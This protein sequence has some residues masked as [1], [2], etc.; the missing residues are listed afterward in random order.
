ML[1]Q[2]RTA[3]ITGGNTGIGAGIAKSFAE[4]GAHVLI[5]YFKGE[6]E[7]RAVCAAEKRAGQIFD[8]LQLDAT[9]R[10]AVPDVVARAAEM[11]GGK[12]D[13]LVNNAGH[14]LKRVPLAEM[15]EDFFE[16]VMD[17]NLKSTFRVTKA[18]LPFIPSGGNIV[19]MAS[20]AAFN[21]GSAGAGAYAASKGAVVSLTRG[22]A[23]E[24]AA[25]GIRVNVVAPGFIANTA[26]HNTFSTPEAQANMVND[27]LVKRGGTPADVAGTVL[28]LVS[29]LSAFVTGEVIQIN[30]GAALL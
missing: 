9:D 12:L 14:L 4:H 15:D 6:Q 24:F 30:G 16:A 27:T 20:L 28:Y 17:V 1:L 5:T 2:G 7:A 21:G 22:M 26:F 29:D 10:A 11:L 8:T 25:R 3:L 13:I 18:A 23:K 19:N